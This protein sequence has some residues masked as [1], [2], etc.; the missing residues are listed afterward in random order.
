MNI[1]TWL[2]INE[3]GGDWRWGIKSGKSLWY[4]SIEI[5]RVQDNDWGNMIESV[6]VK[7]VE[8]FNPKIK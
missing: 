8:T 4:P 3:I 7:L 5:L 1:P 6:K 2:M